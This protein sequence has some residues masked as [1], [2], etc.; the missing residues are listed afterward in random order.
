MEVKRS[1]IPNPDKKS[2]ITT[3]RFFE[4]ILGREDYKELDSGCPSS[5]GYIFGRSINDR[6]FIEFLI[7]PNP[8]GVF[9]E[10]FRPMPDNIGYFINIGVPRDFEKSKPKDLEN[11]INTHG[12]IP[13]VDRPWKIG[14]K[15]MNTIIGYVKI[16]VEPKP[17]PAK[18]LRHSKHSSAARQPSA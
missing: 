4:L 12:L 9:D 2:S 6:E 10:A 17:V 14:E 11:A 16:T 18:R 1:N 3:A 8:M 5:P 15:V 7:F 13:M